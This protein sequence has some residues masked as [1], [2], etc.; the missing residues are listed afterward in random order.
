V[1]A[2][3][4]FALLSR[5]TIKDERDPKIMTETVRLH[6]LVREVAAARLAGE[7]RDDTR[8]A[9]IA[10]LAAVYP[11]DCERASMIVSS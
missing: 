11:D 7:A 2:L 3:R 5:E 9:L 4:S 1:A 6:R 10:A 8:R